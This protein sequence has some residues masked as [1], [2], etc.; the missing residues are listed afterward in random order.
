MCWS[1]F[2][3]TCQKVVINGC[4]MP[5][6]IESAVWLCVVIK[7]HLIK[8]AIAYSCYLSRFESHDFYCCC[9]ISSP[10]HSEHHKHVHVCVFYVYMVKH[11]WVVTWL[12]DHQYTIAMDV[13][14]MFDVKKHLIGDILLHDH[15]YTIAMDVCPMF[16]V[17]KHLIGDI[18][19]HDHQY[20]M[21]VG[22]CS[23]LYGQTHLT[24]DLWLHDHQY[25]IN[26]D[27]CSMFI[28]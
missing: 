7:M 20:T 8:H 18:L 15:Q 21:N 14:P 10:S 17:K 3:W 24:G 22:V 6:C 1:V 28:W 13:C 16:D 5:M 2:C 4:Y 23:M 9:F 19:L 26:M 27:V 25:I 12:H 11:I